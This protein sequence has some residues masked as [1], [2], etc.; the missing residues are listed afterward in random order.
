MNAASPAVAA[1]ADLSTLAWISSKCI[2]LPCS[3]E[4]DARIAQ[5]P[6]E[7]LACLRV[8]FAR[9]SRPATSRAVSFGPSVRLLPSPGSGTPSR[10]VAEPDRPAC[11][12]LMYNFAEEPGRRAAAHLMT[13][14][15]ARRI[16][17]SIAKLP[18]LL[19]R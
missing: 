3:S 5:R 12:S 19:R 6:I 9:R 4:H 1:S 11:P 16:A 15:E 2:L 10:S 17:V 13:R 18:E 14:D 7:G 8:T